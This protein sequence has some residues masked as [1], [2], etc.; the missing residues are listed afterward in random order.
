MAFLTVKEWETQDS[1]STNRD[2]AVVD[3][4]AKC[5]IKY[6]E[7]EKKSYFRRC[8]KDCIARTR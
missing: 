1:A 6:S 3:D 5:V 2:D 4:E 7:N 8:K